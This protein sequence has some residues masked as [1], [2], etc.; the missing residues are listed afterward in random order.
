MRHNRTHHHYQQQR[1]RLGLNDFPG[2]DWQ[3][4][5]EYTVLA[6]GIQLSVAFQNVFSVVVVRYATQ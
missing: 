3:C 6:A 4:W 2:R 1:I 5:E